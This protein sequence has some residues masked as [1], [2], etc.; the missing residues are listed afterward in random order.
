[1]RGRRRKTP[2][3]LIGKKETRSERGWAEWGFELCWQVGKERGA[4]SRCQ[5]QQG[6]VLRVGV[7]EVSV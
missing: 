3:V 1:V 5:L 7:S 2:T 6:R 4:G